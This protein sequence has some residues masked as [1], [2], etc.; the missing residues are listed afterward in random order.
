[1]VSSTD[2]KRDRKFREFIQKQP[3]AVCGQFAEYL[4]SGEGRSH[5][6]HVRRA[7]N[8]GT[9]CKPLLSCIPLCHSCHAL[10]HAKGETALMP[11]AEWDR[12]VKKYLLKWITEAA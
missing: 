10:Q 9:A 5:A 4:E 2:T 11:K 3:C 8:S 12:L 7:S 1:M 6:A